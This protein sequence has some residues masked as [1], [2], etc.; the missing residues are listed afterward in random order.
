MLVNTREFSR[1]AQHFMKY[2]YYTNAPVGTFAYQ[3]YWDEQL[4]RCIEG[5]TVGGTR[6]TGPFYGYLN[7]CQL[8][9]RFNGNKKERKAHFKSM[10]FPDFYDTDHDYFTKLE[11]ARLNEKG[12]IV[13]K[14]RRKGFSYKNAWLI[15]H[16][17]VT[18]RDSVNI[19]LYWAFPIQSQ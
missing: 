10:S 13:A 4:K 16:Q 8:S 12:M 18:V 9:R 15:A 2:G 5:Y 17:F 19:V 1:D 7:F 11:E 3:E 6:I 14:S